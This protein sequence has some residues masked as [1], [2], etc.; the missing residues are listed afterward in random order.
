MTTQNGNDRGVD[1]NLPF[2]VRVGNMKRMSEII[3]LCLAIAFGALA[4]AF[5]YHDAEASKSHEQVQQQL[6][7]SRKQ[8]TD[9]IKSLVTQQKLQTCI[10]SLPQG[11]RQQAYENPNSLCHRLSKD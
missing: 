2:G 7:E 3:S 5:Y 11:E 10:L 1:V 6:Q 8:M 9:A 4:T